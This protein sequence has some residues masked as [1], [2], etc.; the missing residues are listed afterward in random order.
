MMKNNGRN[1]ASEFFIQPMN[2]SHEQDFNAL[3]TFVIEQEKKAKFPGN[4]DCL[5]R[6][7]SIFLLHDYQ[8]IGKIGLVK[9]MTDLRDA[10]NGTPQGER[11]EESCLVVSDAEGIVS[12]HNPTHCL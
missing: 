3:A 12:N 9:R 6:N 5:L 11:I 7:G 10:P 2:F 8:C 4:R 1:F